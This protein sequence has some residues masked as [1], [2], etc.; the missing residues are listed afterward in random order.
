M[1]ARGTI[2]AGLVVVGLAG[3]ALV[4]WPSVEDAAKRRIADRLRAETG[5][6]WRIESVG[7]TFRPG[8]QLVARNLAVGDDRDGSG[9]FGAWVREVRLTDPLSLL[10]GSGGSGQAVAEGLSLRAPLAGKPGQASA[11]PGAPSPTGKAAAIRAILRGAK[12]ELSDSGRALSA[13]ADTL[14]VAFDLAAPQDRTEIRASVEFPAYT[15]A[16][17]FALPA[18]SEAAGPFSFTLE[19]RGSGGRRVEAKAEARAGGATFRLDRIRG[20]IDREP[21]SG[22]LDVAWDG[23]RPRI[24]LDARLDALTLT[25]AESAARPDAQSDEGVVVPITPNLVP[26][27]RWFSGIEGKGTLSVARLGLGPARLSNVAVTAGVKDASLDLAIASASGYGG[28]AR[29]RYVL[30][31]DSDGAG[32]HQLGFS[33]NRV[34]VRALLS[35]I[36]GARGIDGS[37]S[38][39]VDLQAKGDAIE[40]VRRSLAGTADLSVTEGRIDGLDLAGTIGLIP[41]VGSRQGG[42][43]TRLDRLAGTFSLAEGQAVTN[44]L[45]VKTALI[46]AKGI[47]SLD[48]IGRT[49]DIRLKPQVIAPGAGR[50][51]GGRNPLDVP[52]RIAGPWDSPSVSADLSGL[53]RD[54]AG[55]IESLQELGKGILGEDGGEL[56][57]AL[58]GLLEGFM[59]K[60]GAPPPGRR[61]SRPLDDDPGAP[62]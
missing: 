7:L 29:G 53:A 55:A 19:P 62:R 58:G 42:L 50:A 24:A 5:R 49:M 52:V 8:L 41:S 34:K 12:A 39:R 57:E 48:L 10:L 14:E 2:L 38:L 6:P 21:F 18:G 20:T 45:D 13:S 35:D 22:S 9:V 32:R 60:P 61:R 11:D 31:P 16:A 40:A 46:E 33:L 43:A 26:D 30:A 25:D 28:A 1:R 3:S 54:P 56:G 37:G 4:A 44:D 15:A 59:G 27:V 36:A 51:G 17:T 47:G 23:P